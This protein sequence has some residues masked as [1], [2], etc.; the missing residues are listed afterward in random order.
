MNRSGEK[1]RFDPPT[2][3]RERG[4][5]YPACW[6]L[7]EAMSKASLRR[8]AKTE[9]VIATDVYVLSWLFVATALLL[10]LA[11]W[12]SRCLAVVALVICAYRYIDIMAMLS[13]KLIR[14]FI[15]YE[16][17]GQGMASANRTV[18]LL[19]LNGLEICVLFAMAFLSVSLVT[20]PAKV[21][22]VPALSAG[23]AMYFSV[24]TATT[25]GYGDIFP[26]ARVTKTLAVLEVLSLFLIFVVVIGMVASQRPGISDSED[27]KSES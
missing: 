4:F 15:S 12:G 6:W 1:T 22:N 24:V 7:L 5:I 23:N 25:L 16:P 21:W 9:S 10:V 18:L 26:A 19:L 3:G 14:R 11:S 13:S 2:V 8:L 27:Q 17:G 20:Y